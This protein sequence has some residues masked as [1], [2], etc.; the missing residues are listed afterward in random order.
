[1]LGPGQSVVAF[2]N[3]QRYAGDPRGIVLVAHAVIQLEI[4]PPT[5]DPPPPYAFPSGY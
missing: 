4:T 3:G 1:M 5:I 2:V